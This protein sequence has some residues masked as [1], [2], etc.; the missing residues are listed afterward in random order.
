MHGPESSGLA[1][2]STLLSPTQHSGP[3]SRAP[4]KDLAGSSHVQMEKASEGLAHLVKEGEFLQCAVFPHGSDGQVFGASELHFLLQRETLGLMVS[5]TTRTK[6]A[7]NPESV[8]PCLGHPRYSW[9]PSIEGLAAPS[10]ALCEVGPLCHDLRKGK[11][12]SSILSYLQL[13]PDAEDTW[14]AVENEI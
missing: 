8:G 3:A 14:K 6:D 1:L 12:H 2:R 10:L 4:H 5:P 11:A 9:L 13:K 7:W